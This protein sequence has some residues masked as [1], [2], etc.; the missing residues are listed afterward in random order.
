MSIDIMTRVWK[1]STQG[2]SQLLLLLAISDN[3]NDDG[4]A[5]PG[6]EYLAKK[7]RMSSKS[8]PRLTKKLQGAGELF[9]HNR[10]AKGLGTQYIILTDMLWV[11]FA[12][13]LKVYLKYTP[14]K[15]TKVK[16][17]FDKSR[18]GG[19]NWGGDIAMGSG[20]DIAM[21]SGVDTAMGTEPSLTI[22]EP[23]LSPPGEKSPSDPDLTDIL[24]ELAEDEA[25][26]DDFSDL[27]T[28]SPLVAKSPPANGKPLTESDAAHLRIFGGLPGEP[29]SEYDIIQEMQAAHWDKLT[30]NELRAIALY[31]MAVRRKRPDFAI[32]NDDWRRDNWKTAVK[33]HLKDY[34]IDDLGDLYFSAVD[35]LAGIKFSFTQ[36]KALTNTLQDI[37]N[38][39]MPTQE[40]FDLSD[41][42][43]VSPEPM[44]NPVKST[45]NPLQI[46]E[47]FAKAREDM[48]NAND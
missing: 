48:K 8:I 17:W 9:I 25:L 34:R 46:D 43:I 42:K 24:T 16:E 33:G 14:A 40:Q 27:T 30:T 37:V 45:L 5:Y 35:K 3:A 47:K 31:I 41:Y 11:D 36:P 22:S 18:G 39:P 19:T 12:K 32:P 26:A 10:S 15:I 44:N 7:I 28:P 4:F 6:H 1:K 29:M 13:T 2:G 21:G 23:S 20:V 38:E